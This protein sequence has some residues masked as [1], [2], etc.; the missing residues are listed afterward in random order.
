MEAGDL[1][2]DLEGAGGD[3]EFFDY[4]V[5]LAAEFFVQA[6]G[7]YLQEVFYNVQR[8]TEV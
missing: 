3:G 7:D 1:F 6:R 8:S 4:G 2:Q 5:E